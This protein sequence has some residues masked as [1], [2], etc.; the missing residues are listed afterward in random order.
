M[1]LLNMVKVSNNKVSVQAVPVSQKFRLPQFT[2]NSHSEQSF[3]KQRE[4]EYNSSKSIIQQEICITV[5]PPHK[6][7]K[8]HTQ[9]QPIGLKL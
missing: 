3:F 9:T 4:R 8:L 5:P 1:F 7:S 6:L 2:R